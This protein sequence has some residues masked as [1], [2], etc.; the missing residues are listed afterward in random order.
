MLNDS[1]DLIYLRVLQL[2][3]VTEKTLLRIVEIY[4]HTGTLFIKKWI[5]RIGAKSSIILGGN[6]PWNTDTLSSGLLFP[7]RTFRMSVVTSSAL[8][9]HPSFS[10]IIGIFLS[11]LNGFCFLM[12]TYKL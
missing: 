12:A 10:H 2:V 9:L 1:K 11:K 3:H 7:G 5:V 6:L 4:L 8:V